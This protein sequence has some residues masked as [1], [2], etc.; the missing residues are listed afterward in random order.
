MDNVDAEVFD[1]IDYVALGHIHRPQKITEKIRYSGS[2]LKYSFS[3]IK[4]DKSVT[5][6]E[7][8]EKG[9]IKTPT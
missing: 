8:G 1:G 2:I 6:V 7:I 4:Y 3:E 5:V 9:K